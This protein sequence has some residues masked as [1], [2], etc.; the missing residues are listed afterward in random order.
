MTCNQKDLSSQRPALL[1]GTVL[2]LCR[3]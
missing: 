1:F 2:S 3:L